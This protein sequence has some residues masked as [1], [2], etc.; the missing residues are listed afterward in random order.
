VSEG[1]R[2]VQLPPGSNHDKGHSR[3]QQ[4]L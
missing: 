4:V 2:G 3:E 1:L